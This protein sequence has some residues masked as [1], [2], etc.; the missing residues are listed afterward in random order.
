M[1]TQNNVQYLLTEYGVVFSFYCNQKNFNAG[2]V[3]LCEEVIP[4]YLC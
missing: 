1:L 3:E 4:I 2:K